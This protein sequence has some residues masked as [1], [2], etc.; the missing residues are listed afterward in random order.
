VS[1]IIVA[2]CTPTGNGAIGIIRLSGTGCIDLIQPYFSN[3]ALVSSTGN[4]VHFG[5]IKNEQNVLID[6]CLITVFK[7]P[8][9]YTKEDVIEISC[10]GS[11]YI[12]NEV[13]SLTLRLGARLAEGGEFTQRAFLNGQMDLSQAEAVAELIASDNYQSHQNLASQLLLPV[14]RMLAN[15]LY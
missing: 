15:Q 11:S 13:L 5:Q 1:N 8:K 3:P 2:I 14:N 9:S 4:T 7:G 10:H 12:L 6:E